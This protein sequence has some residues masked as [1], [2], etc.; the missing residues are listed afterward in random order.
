MDNP[1]A[2]LRVASVVEVLT[3]AVLL[4]NLFTAHDPAI[5]AAM[6]PVHGLTYLTVVVCAMLVDGLPRR[7]KMLAWIPVVGGL[8]AIR[9]APHSV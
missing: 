2:I 9:M 4:G 1:I 7:A 5:S 8:L 3:L 6:G